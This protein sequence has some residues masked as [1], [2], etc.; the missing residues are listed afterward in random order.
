MAKKKNQN[1]SAPT[2]TEAKETQS[3]SYEEKKEVASPA[4]KAII[5]TTDT[6][7]SE[8]T[9]SGM[10]GQ[11]PMRRRGSRH[12]LQEEEPEAATRYR[13]EF[14]Y[15]K[16]NEED[17]LEKQEKLWDLMKCYIGTDQRSI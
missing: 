2:N 4:G 8:E 3:N 12:D 6:D 11:K 15:T 16:A 7:P 9:K 10:S 5:T 17:T 14:G 13:P 1:N